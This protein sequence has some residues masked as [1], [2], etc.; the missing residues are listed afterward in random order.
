MN[1][2]NIL[3]WLIVVLDIAFVGTSIFAGMNP[4]SQSAIESPDNKTTPFQA[5]LAWDPT[6]VADDPLVRMPGTQPGQVSLEGPNRCL[7]CH[8]EYDQPVEPTIYTYSY[9]HTH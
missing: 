2:R 1:I 3:T 6:P 9:A 7:N 5:A 4:V 8:G